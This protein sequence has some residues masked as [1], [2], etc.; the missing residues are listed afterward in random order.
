MNP[1]NL[2]P[3]PTMQDEAARS[4]RLPETQGFVDDAVILSLI[5]G[6]ISPRAKV[7][8]QD[9]ALS[10]DDDFAGWHF[11]TPSPFSLAP[12]PVRASALTAEPDFMPEPEA[13]PRAPLFPR[14]PLAEIEPGIGSPHAGK[15]RW[16]LAA[17][18]VIMST[19]LLS[20][21][22]LTLADRPM[23]ADASLDFTPLT[24]PSHVDPSAGAV[25][26]ETEITVPDSN[27]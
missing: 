23:P 13:G 26:H 24:A 19:L 27:P 4:S 25:A 11:N 16:W 12:N 22:L 3:L 17:M 5:A 1:L 15:H 20:Y 7:N 14:R 10:A 18:A 8:R 9:L 6:P 2:S 21:L